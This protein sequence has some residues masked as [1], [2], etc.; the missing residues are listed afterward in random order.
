MNL[1]RLKEKRTKKVFTVKVT[2]KYI[3]KKV[4]SKIL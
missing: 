3:I 1:K 4:V 2:G